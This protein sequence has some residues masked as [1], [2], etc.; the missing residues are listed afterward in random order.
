M[1]SDITK[2]Y[3]QGT[4][5]EVVIHEYLLAN[6]SRN[7]RLKVETFVSLAASQHY[8]EESS[9]VFGNTLAFIF[10]CNLSAC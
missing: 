3:L 4:T 5:M 6:M 7:P 9:F 1:Q 8:V 2:T 10:V